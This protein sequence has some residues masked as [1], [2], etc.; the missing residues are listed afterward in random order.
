MFARVED[1]NESVTLT[2]VIIFVHIVTK[3]QSGPEVAI[4]SDNV[5]LAKSAMSK[6]G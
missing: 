6:V 1:L 3:G 4:F 2:V 5:R